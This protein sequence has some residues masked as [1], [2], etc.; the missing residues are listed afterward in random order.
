MARRP[1]SQP[2][3]VR[4]GVPGGAVGDQRLHL[5]EERPRALDPGEDHRAGGRAV[6]FG[7]EERRGI[8]DLAQAVAG[9]LEDADLVGRAEAVLHRA[10]DAE[11]VAALALE[12][13]HGVDHVLDHARAGDLALLGDVADQHHRD[14]APL[15]EGD[16]LVG[17][18]ADLGDRAGGAVDMVGPH[19]LDRVDDRQRR[20]LGLERGEDVA[21]AGLGG[22]AQRRVGEAEALGAHPDLGG[23]LLARDVDHAVAGPG[24]GGGGLQ[25]QG[26]LA[27]AGVAADEDRR[28]GHEA[29]AEHAVELADA[30]GR[31]GER[32]LGG[33][34]VAEGDAPAAGGAE[35]A[36][37][38]AGGELG[39]LVHGVPGAAAL[40][41]AGPFGMGRAAGG[42][43][44]GGGAAAHLSAPWRSGRWRG[45]G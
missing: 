21:Q 3:T 32:R 11:L 4:R 31:P 29:A 8:G 25:E 35:A 6:A 15:G 36:A 34:E 16:E 39:L 14:A 33:G 30:A 10:Q 12:V 45:R 17:G 7:E 1:E 23:G 38:G 5:D 2:T 19:G 42:A 26:G 41:A 44:E 27:D 18:G 24:E 40:A 20:A 22:E 43:D 9:H 13:E 28:G 37:G